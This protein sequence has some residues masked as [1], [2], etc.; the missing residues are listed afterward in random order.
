MLE[1]ARNYLTHAL[2]CEAVAIAY[3]LQ[4]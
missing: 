1:H 2:T 3:V 4:R